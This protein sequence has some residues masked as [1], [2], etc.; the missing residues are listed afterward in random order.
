M[1]PDRG[2]TDFYL[3]I[4]KRLSSKK[5]MPP[6]QDFLFCGPVPYNIG[7]RPMFMDFALPG[8]NVEGNRQKAAYL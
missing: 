8:Q 1:N 7:F 2:Q 3:Q 6:L 4:E 5:G